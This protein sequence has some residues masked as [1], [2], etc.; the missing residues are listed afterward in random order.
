MRNKPIKAYHSNNVV[1]CTILRDVEKPRKYLVLLHTLDDPV[2]I[3]RALDLAT[4]RRVIRCYVAM[5]ANKQHVRHGLSRRT[6]IKTMRLLG[7]LFRDIGLVQAKRLLTAQQTCT[8]TAAS[9]HAAT[10][11]SPRRCRRRRR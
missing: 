10:A 5:L 1:K 6:A 11:A 4:A 7:A 2:I 3:G 9:G 8:A